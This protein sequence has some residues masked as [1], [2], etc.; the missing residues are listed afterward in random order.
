MTRTSDAVR[1]HFLQAL[2]R[3]TNEREG[4]VRHLLEGKLDRASAAHHARVAQQAD[5][6]GNEPHRQS[7]PQPSPLAALTEA[8]TQ[9]IPKNA[10]GAV[11]TAVS[12]DPNAEG[13]DPGLEAR[14]ELKSIRYFRA[15]WSKLSVDKQ[16]AQAIAHGPENA[17]PL[18]SHQLVLR[19]LAVMRDIAPDYLNRFMSYADTLLWLDHVDSRPVVKTTVEGEGAKKRK[20]AAPRARS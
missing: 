4:A 15:T 3:R 2:A 6:A 18:N 1:L 9:R 12:A 20:P 8:L 10:I 14:P 17:G 16:L 13:R 19:S 5:A 7:T 11:D